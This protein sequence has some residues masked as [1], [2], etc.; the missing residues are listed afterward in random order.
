MVQ[1]HVIKRSP[2]GVTQVVYSGEV[3]ARDAEAVVL[4]ATWDHAERD[5]GYTVFAPG[6][7][8]TEYFYAARWFNIMR[9]DAAA[10][11]RL[12]GWYCNIS[13]PAVITATTVSYDDLYLDLWVDATGTQRVLDEDEFAAAPLDDAMRAAARAGL[14]EAQ[15]WAVTGAGP[16]AE[17]ARDRETRA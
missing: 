13:R 11:G 14:A 5:L 4:R 2:E 3:A 17:L 12:R 16:F 6:D 9:I 7:R 15:L 10:T 1:M 8:F